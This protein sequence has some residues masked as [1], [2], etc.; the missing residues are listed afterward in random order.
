MGRLVRIAMIVFVFVLWPGRLVYADCPGNLALNAGFEGEWYAGSTVGTSLSSFISSDWLPWAVLGD[1]TKEEVGYNFEPEYKILQRS[2]LLDGWYRVYAGEQAQ[3]FFSMYSTHTAGFYQRIAVPAGSTV[4]FSIW[5]QIYTGQED[6]VIDGRY[7]ISDL[8]QPM[9]EPT[10]SV[11]GP[12]DYRAFVG[13]DP[14]GNAP[15]RFGEPLPS[16]ILWSEP[17]LDVQTRGQDAAGKP[18]DEWVELSVTVRAQSDHVTV[19]TKGQPEFRTKHND[20]YWDE[21]CLQV[22]GLATATPR[23]SA[24]PPAPATLAPRPTVT[25]RP[26]AAPSPSP[27]PP[28]ATSTILPSRTPPPPLAQV[29]ATSQAMTATATSTATEEPMVIPT[30]RTA[31]ITLSPSATATPVPE[32]ST[33]RP[34]TGLVLLYILNVGLIGAVL[35][36]IRVHNRQ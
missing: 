21:A 22:A 23:A 31:T 25:A 7:P 28:M 16:G 30:L 34:R 32:Q 15:E 3:A 6:L 4:T 24:V 9:T 35:R 13:I 1:P 11:K 5:V 10:R 2:V 27:L 14:Y 36:W 29:P 33:K 19:Y 17:V 20:S 8:V 12:G 26:T 18:V